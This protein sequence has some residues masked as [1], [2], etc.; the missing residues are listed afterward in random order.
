MYYLIITHLAWN[1]SEKLMVAVNLGI[2]WGSGLLVKRLCK[3]LIAFLL[4][5]H[6]R[7]KTKNHNLIPAAEMNIAFLKTIV[8]VDYLSFGCFRIMLGLVRT[9]ML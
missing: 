5:L 6:S 8:E 9:I 4:K 1:D 7:Q 3:L 2:I